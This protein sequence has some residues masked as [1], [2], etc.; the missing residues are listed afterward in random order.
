MARTSCR[1]RPEIVSISFIVYRDGLI[2]TKREKFLLNN[3]TSININNLATSN[4]LAMG[5]I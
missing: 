4:R 3:R 1:R 2:D 5:L